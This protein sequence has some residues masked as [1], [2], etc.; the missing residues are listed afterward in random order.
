M[1]TLFLLINNL[2]MWMVFVCRFAPFPRVLF[3]SGV[4]ALRYVYTNLSSHSF[5][6]SIYSDCFT[7]TRVFILGA[8]LNRNWAGVICT[9]EQIPPNMRHNNKLLNNSVEKLYG[10]NA[11]GDNLLI[12]PDNL[13]YTWKTQIS[14]SWNYIFHFPFSSR[15]FT[16]QSHQCCPPTC[17]HAGISLSFP[18]I[19]LYG[20]FRARPHVFREIPEKNNA[21]IVWRVDDVYPWITSWQERRRKTSNSNSTKSYRA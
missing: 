1:Q 2:V 17:L 5:R 20:L 21:G 9:S 13:L 4:K 7:S 11:S 8:H 18:S 3:I 10:S 6:I 12:A 14:V 16:Q 19:I 15:K